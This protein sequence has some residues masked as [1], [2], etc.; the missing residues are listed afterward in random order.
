MRNLAAALLILTATTGCTTQNPNNQPTEHVAVA[1]THRPQVVASAPSPSTTPLVATL[2]TV[3]PGSTS[4]LTSTSI[5]GAPTAPAIL[6]NGSGTAGDAASEFVGSLLAGKEPSGIANAAE[7][8]TALAGG[9][10]IQITMLADA[11]GRGEVVVS[12]AFPPATDGSITDPV[13]IRIQLQQTE[14]SVWVV[15]GIGY[16]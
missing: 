3:Q 11:A 5:I 8:V 7:W 15:T 12:I 16:L 14:A 1:T 4:T 6:R 10:V 2:A 9:E 13:G